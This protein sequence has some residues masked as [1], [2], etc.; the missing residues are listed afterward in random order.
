MGRAV[1]FA[2]TFAYNSKKSR[3]TWSK[4]LIEKVSFKLKIAYDNKINR[5]LFN[6]VNVLD[7]KKEQKD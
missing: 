1:F 5:N 2:P 4:T 3:K 6:V 7:T